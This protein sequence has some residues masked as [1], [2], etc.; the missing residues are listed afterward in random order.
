MVVLDSS[1]VPIR[2]FHCDDSEPFTRLVAYWLDEQDDMEH[3]GAAHS[4]EDALAALPEARPD[5]VLLD[6]M[7]SPGDESLLAPIRAAA[8]DAAV[9]VYSGWVGLLREG[10]LGSSADAYVDKDDDE[11]ALLQAIR[12]VARR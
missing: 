2:V 5:V 4:G 3:V 6:T 1:G 7:G 12:A 11:H 8:P 10:E 9:I